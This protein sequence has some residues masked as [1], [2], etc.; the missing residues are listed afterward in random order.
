MS[1][2]AQVSI[3]RAAAAARADRSAREIQRR[4]E[5]FAASRTDDRPLAPVREAVADICTAVGLLHTSGAVDYV[6]SAHYNEFERVEH[7]RK[8]RVAVRRLRRRLDVIY[9]GEPPGELVDVYR[10]MEAHDIDIIESDAKF[11]LGVTEVAP[12]ANPMVERF[13]DR[14]ELRQLASQGHPALMRTLQVIDRAA[15]GDEA[16]ESESD[17]GEDEG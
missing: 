1:L 6:L 12:P 17:W 10:N 9:V 13:V 7:L 5:I 2:Q 8:M 14:S 11:L 15:R 16:S 3:A 4:T